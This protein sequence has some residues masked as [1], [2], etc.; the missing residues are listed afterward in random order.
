MQLRNLA[1]VL[2]NDVQP[3][4]TVNLQAL[5]LKLHVAYKAPV[6][7]VPKYDSYI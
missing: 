3:Y 6:I 1:S 2:R 7:E 4:I 5:L